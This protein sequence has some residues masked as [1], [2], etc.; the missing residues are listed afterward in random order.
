MEIP[1]GAIT[2]FRKYLNE[3]YA[4]APK[5]HHNRYQQRKRAY[6]DYLYAQDR[7]KFMMELRNWLQKENR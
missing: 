2:R 7:D 5:H 3:T 1:R 6:G 4:D